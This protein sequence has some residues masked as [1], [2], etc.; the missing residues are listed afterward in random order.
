MK[1]SANQ[2]CR[3]MRSQLSIG[4]WNMRTILEAEGPI[5]FKPG[6]RGVAV[7]RKVSLMIQELKKYSVNLTAIS[8]TKW[9]GKAICQVDCYTIFHSG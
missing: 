4:C 1:G 5:E 2:K 8:E 3:K 9:F 7:D 6:N